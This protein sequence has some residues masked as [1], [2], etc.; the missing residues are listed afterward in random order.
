MNVS[1]VLIHRLFYP[2]VPAVLSTQHL[3]RVSAMPVVSYA[4]VSDS[5]PLV[6]VACNPQSFTCKLAL[7]ASSFSLSIL[8]RKH[9]NAMAKLATTRGSKVKDKLLEAGLK[10]LPGSKLKVPVIKGA[11]ATLECVL[12]DKWTLGD[13][14]LLVGQ[15][16]AASASDAFDDFWNFRKYHPIL[17]TGWRDGLTTLPGS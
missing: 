1:P 16:E 11:D 13:H 9:A 14:L 6:A 4:S 8:S 3:G 2:Q 10:H 7:K 17:Y 15:V 12:R 5:P